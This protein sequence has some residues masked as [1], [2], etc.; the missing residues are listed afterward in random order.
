M[1]NFRL[2]G[3]EGG[4]GLFKILSPVDKARITVCLLSLKC[5]AVLITTMNSCIM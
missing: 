1:L 5:Y 4:E 2:S 3:G